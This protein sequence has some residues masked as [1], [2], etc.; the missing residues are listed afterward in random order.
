MF[1]RGDKACENQIH[2]RDG[3]LT[4]KP[5]IP[6]KLQEKRRIEFI[7]LAEGICILL[8]MA[9]HSSLFDHPWLHN[10]RMPLYFILSGLFFKDYGGI[11]ATTVKKVNRLI[12]PALF[13]TAGGFLCALYL[14]YDV[15]MLYEMR[16]TAVDAYNEP[17]W[18]LI[19]LFSLNVIFCIIV[20][21]TQNTPAIAAICVLMF[22]AAYTIQDTFTPEADGSYLYILQTM[23]AAPYFFLGWVIRRTPLLYDRGKL[24]H[25]L[26]PATV[27]IALSGLLYLSTGTYSDIKSMTGKAVWMSVPCGVL[28]VTGVLLLLKPV[29]RIPFI[30]WIGRYSVIALGV[31]LWA[32]EWTRNFVAK[33]GMWDLEYSWIHFI[34]CVT[35]SAL[36]IYPLRKLFPWFTAQKD[37]IPQPSEWRIP[38]WMKKDRAS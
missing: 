7:D 15:S 18:F 29:N 13:F 5:S 34:G 20:R 11:L 1:R 8:V 24:S 25:T 27:L 17:M 36:A 19:S 28:L 12:I 33:Y 4:G 38:S 31:H 10:L 26:I 22:I 6:G 3:Q 37:L 14:H 23:A 2:L 16:K 32:N 21:I 30:S 35:L 9:Y